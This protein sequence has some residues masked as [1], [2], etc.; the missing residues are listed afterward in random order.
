MESAALNCSRR[1]LTES[2]RQ[3]GVD[4]VAANDTEGPVRF[5]LLGDYGHAR[6]ILIQAH[7]L[8]AGVNSNAARLH[9]TQQDAVQ[10]TALC[11][12]T[13]RPACLRSSCRIPHSSHSAP[14]ALGCRLIPAPTSCKSWRSSSTV[15][16][17]PARCSARAHANPAMPPPT[18]RMSEWGD[19]MAQ[20]LGT[21]R[22]TFETC[23][24]RISKG[25]GVLGTAEFGT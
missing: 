8:L 5:A 7:D 6:I 20:S 22:V 17:A 10:P 11:V 14:T 16:L 9:C 15:T 13:T 2:G 21:G 24:R 23:C 18:H 25:V 12:R 19:V 3:P 1:G 4:A